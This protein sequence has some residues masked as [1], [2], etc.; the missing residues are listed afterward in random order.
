[1]S[2]LGIFFISNNK[3]THFTLT[4]KRFGIS[5]KNCGMIGNLLNIPNLFVPIPS[6]FSSYYCRIPLR[7]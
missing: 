4:C 7:H 3:N 1:M 5:G 6:S 2:I